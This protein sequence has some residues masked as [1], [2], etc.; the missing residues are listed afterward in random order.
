MVF[1]CPTPHRFWRRREY[2]QWPVATG[3]ERDEGPNQRHH[4]A[5]H[6][7]FRFHF[8][9]AGDSGPLPAVRIAA[10]AQHSSSFNPLRLHFPPAISS[11]THGAASIRPPSIIGRQRI[12]LSRVIRCQSEWCSWANSKR[13]LGSSHI[14]S[15]PALATEVPSIKGAVP[16]TNTMTLLLESKPS[17]TQP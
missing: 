1:N 8:G 16:H 7:H 14:N 15:T 11:F 10:I 17:G 2:R 9:W 4:V 6:R 12:T 13:T 5:R 3:L